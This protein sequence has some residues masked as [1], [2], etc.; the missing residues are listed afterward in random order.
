MGQK[1]LMGVVL[2]GGEGKR[3]FPLTRDRAKPA[4]P[5]GGCY[6]LVDFALSNLV[7]GGFYRIAVLTQYK[8]HSLD[9]HL[10]QTWRLSPLL[11]NYVMPVPAQMREGKRW[12]EGSADAIFQNLNLIADEKPDYICVFG[13]DHIYRMDPMQMVDAHIASGAG[14]TVAAIKVPIGQSKEFGILETSGGR[15]A[16]FREKPASVTPLPDDPA[17]IYASMGN[18]VFTTKTLID[19]LHK[20]QAN[21]SS[22]HDMGGNLITMLTEAGEAAHYDFGENVV[23]GTTD[24]DR[25]YWR[26]VGT[27]DA[28]HE[29]H[30]DL[31]SVHPVFNL[32]NAQWPILTWLGSLPPAKF[33][34]DDQDRRGTAIDSLISG[35]VIVSGGTVRRSILSPGAYVHSRAVVEDSIILHGVRIGRG[36]V[37]RRAIL[38]KNVEVPEG[39]QIGVDPERDRAR[40]FTM[41]PSGVVVIGKG[42]RIEA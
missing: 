36:A 30:M 8:S 4:V 28:Y 7:N 2:A 19:A 5:F 29:A 35:G 41:S 11:G 16:H 39:C 6:R 20:D 25:G 26:D 13:A 9:L 24:R 38:D 23:P 10:A 37:V 22:A 12:F 18:Y 33:V 27:L 3:L 40:G 42:D 31:I 34:F 21:K 17:H 15:I 32:Y 1:R 14:V